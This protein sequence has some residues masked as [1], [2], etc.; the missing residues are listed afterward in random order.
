LNLPLLKI[1]LSIV[2]IFI[3]AKMLLHWFDLVIPTTAS[4]IVVATVIL[5]SVLASV[6]LARHKQTEQRQ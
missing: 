4:L 2:L 3:G 1:G 5:L 6:I